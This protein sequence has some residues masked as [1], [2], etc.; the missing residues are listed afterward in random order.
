MPQPATLDDLAAELRRLRALVGSPSYA[1][2]ARRIG[3]LRAERG[4]PHTA[5]G[6]IT[7]YDAFRDGRVH[8]GLI[9]EIMRLAAA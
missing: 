2:L 4:Q 7:V 6:R 1:D 5:P 9:P 3:T 8:T